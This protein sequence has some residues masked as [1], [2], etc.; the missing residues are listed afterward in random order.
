MAQKPVWEEMVQC[1]LLLLMWS[2]HQELSTFFFIVVLETVSTGLTVL[3][4]WKMQMSLGSAERIWNPEA[5]VTEDK[6]ED[7]VKQCH[8]P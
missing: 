1:H 5:W 3:G 6:T 4:G 2:A 8:C 7:G